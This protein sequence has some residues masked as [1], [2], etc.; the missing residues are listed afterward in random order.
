MVGK[1]RWVFRARR[2]QRTVDAVLTVDGRLFH[3]LA[4]ATSNARSPRVSTFQ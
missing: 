2:N 1:M 3:A 4:A